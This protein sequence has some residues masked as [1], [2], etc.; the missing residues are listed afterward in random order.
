MNQ[1]TI[2]V[3]RRT[4]VE[5]A[6]SDVVGLWAVLWQVKNEL[7]SL[8]SEEARAATLEVIHDALSREEIVVGE[9]GGGDTETT[10]FIPWRMSLMDALQRIER[11]WRALAREPNLGDIAWFVA[12]H[13]LPVS[14][15]RSPVKTGPKR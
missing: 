9:F 6:Q 3:I 5:E 15:H 14:M 10:S 2:A 13:L 11:E 8:S 12:P 1:D 7:P 4:L